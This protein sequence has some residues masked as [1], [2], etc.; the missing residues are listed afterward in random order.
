M[1][2]EGNNKK[3]GVVAKAFEEL[4]RPLG[5]VMMGVL[6]YIQWFTGII[7]HDIAWYSAFFLLGGDSA[8]KLVENVMER[9]VKK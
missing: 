5:Y 4:S 7:V 2:E 6:I 3:R 9:I 1:T 8:L